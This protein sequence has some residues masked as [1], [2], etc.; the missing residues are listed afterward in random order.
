V[1]VRVDHAGHDDA[2]GRVHHQRTIR[3]RQ[4]LA[5]RR[6]PVVHHEDVRAGEYRAR[7]VHG[8]HGPAAQEH[9]AVLVH[10]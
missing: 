10:G 9:G 8:Q 5:H 7:V 6:D 4:I 2:V 3:R 1:P